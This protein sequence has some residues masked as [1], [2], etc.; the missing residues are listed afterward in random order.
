MYLELFPGGQR[1][2]WVAC[3]GLCFQLASK[4]GTQGMAQQGQYRFQV[5]RQM[6]QRDPVASLGCT[7]AFDQV[8]RKLLQAGVLVGGKQGM[9][10]TKKMVDMLAL[11]RIGAQGR[12][13]GA[14]LLRQRLHDTILQLLHTDGFVQYLPDATAA[15][16]LFHR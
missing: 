4:L 10:V 12:S 6:P 3:T 2:G 14:W 1:D 7:L 5:V 16:R 9:S 11:C 8:V 15:Q 13:R